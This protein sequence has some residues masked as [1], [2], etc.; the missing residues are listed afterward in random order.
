MK[1]KNFLNLITAVMLVLFMSACGSSG[2]DDD[3]SGASDY[4]KDSG[5]YIQGD[6]AAIVVENSEKSGT[7]TSSFNGASDK[8]WVT[9]QMTNPDNNYIVNTAIYN[10]SAD[11]ASI[12]IGATTKI[13][14][15]DSEGHL[16]FTLHFA[17]GVTTG[18]LVVGQV[19]YQDTKN[20]TTYIYLEG[21]LGDD[22]VA[23]ITTATNVNGVVHI[24]GSFSGTIYDSTDDQGNPK[25]PQSL[26]VNFEFDAHSPSLEY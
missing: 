16:A 18:D 5:D 23:N 1:M 11:S 2:G 9:Y 22:I 20:A 24:K 8:T 26:S 6:G 21:M 4:A 25:D 3:N 7:Y 19:Q 14:T 13:G 15:N 10:G 12:I 17:S